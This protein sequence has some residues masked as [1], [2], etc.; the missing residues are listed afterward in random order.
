MSDR[1]LYVKSEVMNHWPYLPKTQR[2]LKTAFPPRE[3]MDSF[4]LA[5]DGKPQFTP[6]LAWQESAGN[7]AGCWR[8]TT[9]RT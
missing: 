2:V 6:V 7:I 5:L 4:F 9:P 8:S 3:Y 1:S